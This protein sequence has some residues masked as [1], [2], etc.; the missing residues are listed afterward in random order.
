M[1]GSVQGSQTSRPCNVLARLEVQGKFAGSQN[2]L[3][4]YAINSKT[5]LKKCVSFVKQLIN[6]EV[7]H[8]VVMMFYSQLTPI[9][10]DDI[11]NS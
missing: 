4:E 10:F 2:H 5:C 7:L 1:Q 11:R 8:C 6:Q 3:S 9:L